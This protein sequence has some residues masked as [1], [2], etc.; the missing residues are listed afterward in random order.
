M[1]Y[2]Q[3]QT[4]FKARKKISRQTSKYQNI[5]PG[6][7][8]FCV[9]RTSILITIFMIPP[10]QPISTEDIYVGVHDEICRRDDRKSR[11]HTVHELL[12][13]RSGNSWEKPVVIK[14]DGLK[15]IITHDIATL[16]SDMETIL[17]TKINDLILLPFPKVRNKDMI[18]I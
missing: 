10:E 17:A 16:E 6:V 11:Q 18:F 13:S 2:P 15:G 4:P 7:Q 12:L 14:T 1:H 3:R 5:A 8:K 9:R